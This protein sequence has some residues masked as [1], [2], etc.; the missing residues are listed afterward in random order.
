MSKPLADQIKES[1]ATIT[2]RL[3]SD[4]RFRELSEFY[5]EMLK[6]GLVIKREYEIPPVDTI[7]RTLYQPRTPAGSE[8]TSVLAALP[9]RDPRTGK[10]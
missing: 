4:A 5:H 2:A 8:Y 7:G 1:S 6:A 10:P 3:G 9:T